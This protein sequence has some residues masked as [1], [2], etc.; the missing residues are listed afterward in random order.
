[1]GDEMEDGYKNRRIQW[2]IAKIVKMIVLVILAVTV[3]GFFTR[4]L[5]NWLMPSIFGLRAIT[6]WQAIGLC[7]LGKILFGG[8]H[9]HAGGGGGRGWKRHWE[10]RWAA[11][12][13][14]EK[15]RFRAG[16]RNRCDWRGSRFA[17]QMKKEDAAAETARKGVV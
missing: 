7:L 9:K 12:S 4:E 15:E 16:M 6:F 2:K 5:W 8:F 11:M 3:F 14:E 10:Q 1:M 13:D 17:E